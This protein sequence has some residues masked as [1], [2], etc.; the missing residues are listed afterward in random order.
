MCPIIPDSLIVRGHFGAVN[1]E[2]IEIKLM[3]CNLGA[4]MCASDDDVDG[5]GINLYGLTA[6]PTL[7]DSDDGEILKYATEQTYFRFL[8]TYYEQSTNIF[9][10]ESKF[11]FSNN[12][13]DIFL[14]DDIEEYFFEENVRV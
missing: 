9:F 2:Y 6:H 10:M 5:T 13:F 3:G 1:F 14:A 4:G 8:D 7:A 11:S 12:L